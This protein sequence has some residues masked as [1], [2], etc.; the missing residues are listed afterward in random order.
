ML[1]GAAVALQALNSVGVFIVQRRQREMFLHKHF[2]TQVEEAEA[3][4]KQAFEM[5]HGIRS[6]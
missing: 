1:V 4:S 3:L 6:R 2:E 5:S